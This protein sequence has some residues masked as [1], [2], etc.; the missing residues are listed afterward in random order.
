VPFQA[1]AGV[2]VR[3]KQGYNRLGVEDAPHRHI[4]GWV[5]RGA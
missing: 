3:I 5:E 2:I 1:L 4:P